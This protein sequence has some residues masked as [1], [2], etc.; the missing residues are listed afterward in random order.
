MTTVKRQKGISIL[1]SHAA[2]LAIGVGALIIISAMLWEVYDSVIRKQVTSDLAETGQEITGEMLKLYSLKSSSAFPAANSYLLLGSS[3]LNIP[4]KAGGRSYTITA[5]ESGDFQIYLKNLTINPSSIFLS[6]YALYLRGGAAASGA[7]VNATIIEN[8]NRNSTTANQTGYFN[9]TIFASLA[10]K[11]YYNLTIR[12]SDPSGR[13]S[14]LV[15]HISLN[16][17]AKEERND[18]RLVL[19]SQSPGIRVEQQ[20]FNIDTKMQGSVPGGKP[21]SV[22][23]YRYNLN[24]AVEDRILLGGAGIFV[25]LAGIAN[26][27]VSGYAN[28]ANGSA[29]SG[30]VGARISETS[31]FISNTTS[32]GNFTLNLITSNLTAGKIYTLSVTASDGASSGQMQKRF[33]YG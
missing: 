24:G 30:N 2:F 20:L 19:E 14:Y 8:G 4:Q 27:T 7:L 3:L 22:S 29:F 31:D 25:S 28:Y 11:K 1:V 21:A 9:V 23:Y 12:V 13:N 6:G 5:E 15:E 26:A 32:S 33:A 18:A 16:D 10:E 17:T